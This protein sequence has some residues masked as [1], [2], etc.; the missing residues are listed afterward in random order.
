M[1]MTIKKITYSW[2]VFAAVFSCFF[3]ISL[4]FIFSS[5]PQ[6]FIGKFL[7]VDPS[8][9][10][11]LVCSD[12]IDAIGDDKGADGP[13]EIRYPLNKTF[14][15][16]SLDLVR[17]TV[18]QPVTNARWQQSSEYWQLSLEYKSGP[19]S[20]RNIMIYFDAD[21]IEGGSTQPLFDSAEKVIFDDA[22]PWDFALWICGGQGKLYDSEGDFICNTEYYS[23]N[24]DTQINIRIPLSDKRVQKLLGSEKTWHYVLTGAYSQFDRGGFMPVEKK[25]AMAHGGMKNSKEYNSLIPP[26]Y[27]IAGS[28]DSLASW[29][30]DTFEKAKLSPLEAKM[31]AGKKSKSEKEK[32]EAFINQV[33]NLYAKSQKTSLPQDKSTDENLAYYKEKITAN[34]EDYVSLA[35]YGSYLAVKGGESS[36]MAAVAFVN[37]S[38]TYLDKAAQ[39]AEGKEG[40]IEVLMNRA[41]VSASVPEQV[42]GKS[43]TGAEDFMRIV[44]LTDDASLKAYCYV[45]AYECYLKCGKETQAILALQEAQK[46]VQLKE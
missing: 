21:N 20:V 45:M 9:T 1:N 42:F 22:H 33:K 15:E 10:G 30:R 13:L 28:N 3:G 14:E 37:E 23:L 31:T 34:P 7:H 19:A 32:N 41:S 44:S 16:G 25:P 12:F 2:K 4:F 17:Y 5:V 24:N 18:H 46:M 38:Y 29:N 11:G 8:Y 36:V 27:D 43:A 39:M 35:Y 6:Q 40:E 26:L